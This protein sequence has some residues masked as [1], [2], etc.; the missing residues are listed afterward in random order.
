MM[1]RRLPLSQLK[2]YYDEA[3]GLYES[4]AKREELYG[5]IERARLEYVKVYSDL[6]FNVF[7]DKKFGE[8]VKRMMHPNSTL[9]PTSHEVVSELERMRRK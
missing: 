8:L 9:R 1:T 2:P 4:G 3:I 6:D 5:V 7:E